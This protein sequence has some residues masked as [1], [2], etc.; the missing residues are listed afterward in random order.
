MQTK[1]EINELKGIPLVV[2]E[3]LLYEINNGNVELIF[4]TNLHFSAMKQITVVLN[5]DIPET[6]RQE[7][8]E[9]F[10]TKEVFEQFGV[11]VTFCKHIVFPFESDFHFTYLS[12][13]LNPQFI[14][15]SRK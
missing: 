12:L 2:Q 4:A 1:L 15:Y 7:L 5:K 14:I 11:V 3:K 13:Y 10:W 6:K 8:Q 9:S